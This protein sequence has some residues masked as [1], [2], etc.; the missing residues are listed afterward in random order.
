MAGDSAVQ[1]SAVADSRNSRPR[2]WAIR[3]GKWMITLL[4]II[5][6]A[7]AARES[8]TKWQQQSNA[9]R[10]TLAD[11]RWGWLSISAIAYAISLVPAGLVLRRALAALHQP[12]ALRLV[13]AAQLVGHLGKYV[14]GKAMVI[15]LRAS[16]LSRGATKVSIKLSA[17]AVIIETLNLIAVGAVLAM[18]LVI[19]LDT[20]EWIKWGSG[21][22]A[23]GA[24]IGTLPPVLRYVL[25]RR[26]RIRTRR[27]PVHEPLPLMP[28][29]WTM[30]DFAA[31]WFWCAVSWVF[32]GISMT[33]VVMALVPLVTDQSLV[34]LTLICSA[35]AM[36]AFVAGFLSL[37]PGGV[38]VRET[39]L[40]TLLG[41]VIG[42]GPALLSAVVAR[43]VQLAVESILAA[44]IWTMMSRRRIRP[45]DQLVS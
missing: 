24:T 16:I 32:T 3:L 1:A 9:S 23:I 42:P 2:A 25:S 30:H 43:L 15:V 37:L 6:V 19:I 17:I 26:L 5:A 13:M 44:G 8:V 29:D 39:V 45:T 4:V 34:S 20:P 14:P 40:A 12:I 31:A 36:L 11:V 33:A 22:M 21:L 7:F 18:L 10:I 41:P 28:L 27:T 38:G 35:A